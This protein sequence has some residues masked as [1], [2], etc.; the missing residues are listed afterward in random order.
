MGA[1]APAINLQFG[2][3]SLFNQDVICRDVLSTGEKSQNHPPKTASA[4]GRVAG[5]RASLFVTLSCQESLADGR[6]LTVV[7]TRHHRTHRRQI[8]RRRTETEV[9]TRI[10][11]AASTRSGGCHF[12][13]ACRSRTA[14]C[15]S[16]SDDREFART[17]SQADGRCGLP[18][19]QASN[20]AAP[21][22]CSNRRPAD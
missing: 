18:L 5:L 21:R 1:R 17:I 3:M 2:Q 19:D 12:S 14:T 16:A 9:E 13:A 7:Q 11:E 22:V 4:F 10:H 6:T 15:A 8:R 20:S